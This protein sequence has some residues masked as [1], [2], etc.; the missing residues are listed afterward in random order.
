MSGL[1]GGGGVGWRKENEGKGSVTHCLLP[2]FVA[3]M[4]PPPY[5]L[6]PRPESTPGSLWGG[7]VAAP[8]LTRL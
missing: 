3:V 1:E 4:L 7:L 6:S 8:Q 2:L 5:L